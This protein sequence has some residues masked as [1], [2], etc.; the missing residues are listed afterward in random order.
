MMSAQE[1]LVERLVDREFMPLRLAE[2]EFLDH[3]TAVIDANGGIICHI[4]GDRDRAAAIV[5]AC[6]D[7]ARI[8]S[9]ES[10]LADRERQIVDAWNAF[11]PPSTRGGK[12]C[13]LYGDIDV[14]ILAGG[15]DLAG[16]IVEIEAENARL[17]ADNASLREALALLIKYADWTVSDE[18][19]GHHPTL[20]S[21]IGVARAALAGHEHA[22]TGEP[23]TPV[24][25]AA[26]NAAK[27][28]HGWSQ[29]KREYAERAT[30]ETGLRGNCW[31]EAYMMPE[32]FPHRPSCPAFPG[33][34]AE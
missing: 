28:V 29:S 4:T 22:E 13:E 27:R 12:I 6:N 24:M 19:P 15:A 26:E 20:P 14:L 2:Q 33:K 17:L 11:G 7:Q 34:G 31:C 16:N 5:K 23:L 1:G 32:G 30:A 18:S 9:L 10:E 25:Q 21:A 8:T 3:Q